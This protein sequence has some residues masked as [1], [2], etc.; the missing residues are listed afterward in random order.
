MRLGILLRAERCLMRCIGRPLSGVLRG[1]VVVSFVVPSLANT[2]GSPSQAA[3]QLQVQPNS[4]AGRSPNQSLWSLDQAHRTGAE[5]AAL[6]LSGSEPFQNNLTAA[7]LSH[8]EPRLGSRPSSPSS[9]A[10]L[11]IQQAATPTLTPEP[12]TLLLPEA[13]TP[14][15]EPHQEIQSFGARPL[16]ASPL[17]DPFDKE[18]ASGIAEQRYPIAVFNS[19][20]EQTLVV[21][22]DKTPPGSLR[23][24]LLTQ[25]GNPMGV[26][27]GIPTAGVGEPFKP[28]VLHNPADNTYMLLWSEP[29]GGVSIETYCADNC[30]TVTLDTY[31]M[32]ALPLAANGTPLAAS[33]T[34]ITTQLSF[35]DIRLGYGIAYNNNANEYLVAWEQQRGAITGFFI[36]PHRIKGQRLAA[37]GGL[38]GSPVDLKI[39][40]VTSISLAYS[41]VSDE[42]LVSWDRFELGAASYELYG[43]RFDA[44]TLSQN[45]SL[46]FISQSTIGAQVNAR[47]AYAESSDVFQLVFD[48]TSP[49]TILNPYIPDISARAIQA[50]TGALLASASIVDTLNLADYTGAVEYSPLEDLFALTFSQDYSNLSVAY[51][52]TTGELLM[53]PFWISQLPVDGPFDFGPNL[54]ARFSGE[55]RHLTWTAVWDSSADIYARPLLNPVIYPGSLLSVSGTDCTMEALQFTQT[56]VAAPI[57]TRTGGYD[58]A[59]SDLTF[60]TNAGNLEFWRTYS[61][62]SIGSYTE[63]LGPG[64]VHN[65]GANLVFPGDPEGDPGVVLFQADTANRVEFWDNEDGTYSPA[66]GV[67][68][69]LTRDDGPPIRYAVTDEAQRSYEFDESGELLSWSDDQGRTRFYDYDLNERLEAV[70]DDTGD[71]FLAFAYDGQG[72]LSA[73]ADHSGREVSYQYDLSGDLISSTD[74]VGQTWTY[75]YDV[76]HQLVEVFDPRG[77]TVER[78][79]FDGQGRAIRQFDGLGNQVVEITYNADGT[80]TIVDALGNTETHAYDFRGTIT[81]ETNDEGRTDRKTYDLNYRPTTIEDEVFATTTLEWSFDGANLTQVIDAEGSQTD[82]SYDA[83]NN[84]TEV[85]DPGGFLTSY[86]YDGTRLTASTDALGNVTTYTYTVEGFLASTTD[87]RGST[88]SYT[89]DVFGQRITM[90]DSQGSL[91]IYAYD[92]L[93]R[94]TDTTDPLERVTRNEYDTEDRLIRTTRNFDP[95]LP[96]ND[97]NQF[98]IVTEYAYDP[99]GNQI[100]VTDTFGRV[101]QFEYDAANRL[102]RTVDPAGNAGTNTYN[103]AGNLVATADALG[104]TTTYTYDALNRLVST[105]D[106]LGN[107][108]TTTYN[109]DGTVASTSDPLGR[110]TSFQ[111]DD[112]KRVVSVTDPLGNTTTTTYDPA[113][114]VVATA[115]PLGRTTA[116]EYDALNRL[117]RQTNPLGA[118]TEHFYDGV[119]N[120]IQT[121]DP[122]GGA[123]TFT[124]DDLNRLDTTIDA[125]SNTTTY[126]YDAVGNRNAVTD[127]NGHITQ[128][129][130]DALDRLVA[131]TDPLG[132]V[133]TAGYD[134]LGNATSRTD[135]NGNTATSAYDLLNRLTAQTDALSGVTSFTYDPV[136]NQIA[137]TDANSHT[138]TTVYDALNRPVSV[139]DPNGNTTSSNY[140]PVGNLLATTNALGHTTTFAYDALN[141]QVGVSDPLGNSTALGFDPVGNRTSMSDATGVVTRYEYD[142]L[143]RLTAVVEHFVSGA[144]P[145]HQTNVR[146]EYTYDANGNRLTIQDGNGNVTNFAYDALNRQTSERDPLGNT[147]ATGYDPVGNR[148]SLLDAEGF[149]TV[150]NYDDANRLIGI[151]YPA[152]DADVGFAYDAVGNRTLMSDGVGTTSW[153][154]DPLNRPTSVTDPFGGVVGYGYDPV[155]NRTLLGYPDGKQVSYTYDAGNR[156]GTVTDW[157]ALV[158]SYSYD[159]ANRLLTTTLPNGVV[160]SYSHDTAGRL[161]SIFHENGPQ[162]LSSYEYT[163]DPNGNRVQVIENLRLPDETTPTPTPTQTPTLTMTPT[164]TGPMPTSTPARGTPTATATPIGPSPTSTG[165]PTSTP[166]STNTSTA[167]PTSTS[168][169]G[170]RNTPTPGPPTPTPG[171]RGGMPGEGT[172]ANHIPL[173]TEGPSN[174]P[175][176]GWVHWVSLLSRFRPYGAPVLQRSTATPT[177]GSPVTDTPGPRST[178]TSTATPIPTST[179]TPTLTSTP[180]ETA[181]PTPTAGPGLLIVTIDYTYDP[182]QR[183]TAADYSTGEFFH[184]TYDPVGNR[185]TQDTLAGTNAYSYDIANRLIEVDGVIYAWDDNGNLLSDGGSTYTYDHTNRLTSAIQGPDNFTFTY[186]GL[187]DRLEQSHNAALSAYSLDLL[188]GPTQVLADGSNSYLYGR[189]RLAESAT[190][191]YRS[192]LS[193]ALG[194]VRQLVDPDTEA[195]LTQLFGPYGSALSS[196]GSSAT[197]Y[198]F[199]GEWTDQTELINLRSRYY[200]PSIGRFITKD[201]WSGSFTRPLSL[202]RWNYVAN[203]PVNVTDPSGAQPACEFLSTLG[204]L[205]LDPIGLCDVDPELDVSGEFVDIDALSGNTLVPIDPTVIDV[206]APIEC[207]AGFVLLGWVCIPTG[208]ESEAGDCLL[209][210]LS[211]LLQSRDQERRKKSDEFPGKVQLQR[212]ELELGAIL[213][214]DEGDGVTT[215]KTIAALNQLLASSLP[216]NKAEFVRAAA[217]AHANAVRWVEAR[218]PYGVPSDNY[219]FFFPPPYGDVNWRFDIQFFRG[220]HLKR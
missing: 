111:Y 209:F 182:L 170:G 46:I 12:G 50:G 29:N 101:T 37:D 25:A 164:P 59:V 184:Y 96:Q 168:T 133:T 154:H 99:I 63:P 220:H 78:T 38:L 192:H 21:W 147:T 97:Q 206:G 198:A 138:T 130:Y 82:L 48:D 127:A 11:S 8:P 203:N 28:D 91:W 207:G 16:S 205:I 152:P 141:R 39:G 219:R 93:G 132:N 139:T 94:L 186:N 36:S 189:G 108:P 74:V 85:I 145:D 118:V 62:L 84:L 45:G 90:T 57:N 197:V 67:C 201:R 88:T 177:P 123:T 68:G 173:W 208:F 15:R 49:S 155:G 175:P 150:Y 55:E 120:R 13:I 35:W 122:G 56:A 160:S 161:L 121:V 136:G 185:L 180:T 134:A 52:S 181:T 44:N 4:P 187:G 153:V 34:L 179:G 137:A 196:V 73:V 146:T 83:L 143:N 204:L 54:T 109:P 157:D 26:D 115:D 215:A 77:I 5:I 75:L 156:M 158:T 19:I 176:G 76:Q 72:R 188:N 126:T 166:A 42:Y 7:D 14:L 135:A 218:P 116:F 169:P 144:T 58:F 200:D 172:S 23:G 40:V 70:S 60:P 41:S 2:S 167:T 106:P 51:L 124:Y 87:A 79:E 1:L 61:S 107:S 20:D 190:S 65:H 131:T 53:G 100:A 33:P 129:A 117:I 92:A 194:S 162:L 103:A 32:Y 31:D 125:L 114:N 64:W 43:Q 178:P 195:L 47:M 193:D 119:G 128:L 27:F 213:L 17:S 216:S 149:T 80:S 71:R 140:D 89:Y 110:S 199:T 10:V 22:V 202:N 159:A 86:A 9:E 174:A 81:E 102:I 3:P 142:G 183:L 214:R 6:S 69:T 163:Y 165:T 191:G 113:G 104:R 98:N 212:G 171:G 24:R 18:V 211:P 210:T 148:I 66:P 217:V 95:G 30:I 105:T 151:N 112:L